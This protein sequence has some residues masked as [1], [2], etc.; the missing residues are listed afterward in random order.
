[1]GSIWKRK[2]SV[3]PQRRCRL[4][5]GKGRFRRREQPE[6]RHKGWREQGLLQSRE[7]SNETRYRGVEVRED[8]RV[9]L[10]GDWSWRLGLAMDGY[11]YQIRGMWE[12]NQHL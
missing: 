10:R 4:V 11:D 2:G 7:S 3:G 9:W 5:T 1:M 6:H 12:A 8:E